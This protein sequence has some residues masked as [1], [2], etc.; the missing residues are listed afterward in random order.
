MSSVASLFIL[1]WFITLTDPRCLSLNSICAS[2]SNLSELILEC[3]WVKKKISILL[4]YELEGHA[5]AQTSAEDNLLQNV[6]P[7]PTL[8][9]PPRFMKIGPVVTLLTNR[10]QTENITN[11]LGGGK[12]LKLMSSSVVKSFTFHLI[13]TCIKC[14][15]IKRTVCFTSFLDA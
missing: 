7:W 10:K 3:H 4:H 14:K 13:C 6:L 11:V 2:L 5:R 8:H 12:L 1:S 15:L 9:L